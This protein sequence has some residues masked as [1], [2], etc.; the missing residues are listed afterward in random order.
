MTSSTFHDT[1]HS[2]RPKN[3]KTK[4]TTYWV[5]VLK[6]NFEPSE[7]HKED[8]FLW[9]K[10]HGGINVKTIHDQYLAKHPDRGE[11]FLKLGTKV[12]GE[13]H[14]M[15]DLDEFADHLLAFEAVETSHLPIGMV[16]DRVP[17]QPSNHQL[18]GVMADSAELGSKTKSPTFSPGKARGHP[19]QSPAFDEN[20]TP[21]NENIIP[22]GGFRSPSISSDQSSLAIAAQATSYRTPYQMPALTPRNTSL[23]PKTPVGTNDTVP[24]RV[25]K[26]ETTP[27]ILNRFI[28][29]AHSD[30]ATTTGFDTFADIKREKYNMRKPQLDECKLGLKPSIPMCFY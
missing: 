12:P 18:S 26:D 10:C 30:W 23:G 29:P 13:L 22:Q 25:V 20:A 1:V 6:S 9:I 28:A 17:L 11:V 5:A 24:T 8:D 27:A 3:Q 21:Q 2:L 15:R 4:P 19:A 16:A 14:S 7:N